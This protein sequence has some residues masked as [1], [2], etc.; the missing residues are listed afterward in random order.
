VS[1]SEVGKNATL[2]QLT[3]RLAGILQAPVT[4]QTGITGNY[5][6]RLDH[7]TLDAP[8]EAGPSVFESVQSQ[9]GLKLEAHKGGL[10]F[11]VIDSAE[12]PSAN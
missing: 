9:L 7:R 10:E 4:D 2:P 12:K 11:L 8:L 6:F 5:D 1:Y 3:E